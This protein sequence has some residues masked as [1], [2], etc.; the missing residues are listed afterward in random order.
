[1]TSAASFIED[2]MPTSSYF[3]SRADYYRQLADAA[4]ESSGAACHLG[5]A[6]LFLQLS[7]DLRLIEVA[8][9]HTEASLPGNLPYFRG[10]GS[11]N[12]DCRGI[13][14]V[15]CLRMSLR[16]LVRCL[17]HA[18][19]GIFYFPELIIPTHSKKGHTV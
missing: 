4:P 13:L 11:E 10:R 8:G 9:A 1:M 7:F 17:R 15:S 6:N 5:L 16:F 19:L 3:A 14:R 12:T 18:L 2:T